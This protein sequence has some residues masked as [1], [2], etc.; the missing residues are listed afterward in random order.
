MAG[1]DERRRGRLVGTAKRGKTQPRRTVAATTVPDRVCHV[2]APSANLRRTP[3]GSSDGVV[4][5]ATTPGPNEETQLLRDAIAVVLGLPAAVA[6]RFAPSGRR[7]SALRMT[8]VAAVVTLLTIAAFNTTTPAITAFKTTPVDPH[9]AARMTAKRR[10]GLR[11]QRCRSSSTSAPP[12]TPPRSRPRRPSSRPLRPSRRGRTGARPCSSLHVARGRP[13]PVL[14]GHRRDL[15]RR[16]RWHR[17]GGTPPR[18][19][20]FTHGA[21]RPR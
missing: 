17:P 1:P 3:N 5:P 10:D 15:G 6:S 14:H 11:G 12:W 20:F 9:A 7:R 2:R 4:A 13:G 8:A 16:R 21:A 19:I 18:V